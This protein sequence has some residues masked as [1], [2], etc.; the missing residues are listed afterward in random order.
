VIASTV[1]GYVGG[2]KVPPVSATSGIFVVIG[3]GEFFFISLLLWVRLVVA[4]SRSLKDVLLL[5]D[6]FFT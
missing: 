6:S 3:L 2:S 4:S 5:K 1:Y